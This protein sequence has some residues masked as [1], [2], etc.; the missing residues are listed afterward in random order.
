ML[1]FH[2]LALAEVISQL[3]TPSSAIVTLK[4][5][6]VICPLTQVTLTLEL[7][8][9]STLT[10][11]VAGTTVATVI[12]TPNSKDI[13]MGSCARVNVQFSR[14]LVDPLESCTLFV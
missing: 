14:L 12:L 10:N 7:K 11:G 13:E 4:I 1:R 3:Y 6:R 2:F 5:I 9:G 8:G